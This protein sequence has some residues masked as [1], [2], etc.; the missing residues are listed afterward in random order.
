MK[1]EL[2]IEDP[3]GGSCGCH[4]SIKDRMALVNRVRAEAQIWDKTKKSYPGNEFIRTVLSAKVPE[5]TYPEYVR[6]S[7][8][9]GIGLP[10][11][12]IDGS[13]IHSGSYPGEAEFNELIRGGGNQKA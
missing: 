13:L 10:L 8:K 4:S 9:E 12:F 11:I 1:I 6:D 5:S 2:Y 3:M 7:L